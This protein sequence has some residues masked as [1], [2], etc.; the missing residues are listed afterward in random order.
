MADQT[1]VKPIIVYVDDEKGNRVV[2]EQ[3]LAA[4]FT[5]ETFAEGALALER[6]EQGNVGV[7][8]TDMRMPTMD[9]EELLGSRRS[10]FRK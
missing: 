3:S 2:F 10:G 1:V 8:V 4:D 9:G 7:L 6:L 5:I